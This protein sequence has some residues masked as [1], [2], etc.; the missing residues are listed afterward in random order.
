[1]LTGPPATV[2]WVSNGPGKDDAGGETREDGKTEISISP[3][4]VAEVKQRV[5]AV[6][7][8]KHIH[9]AGQAHTCSTAI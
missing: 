5:Q 3:A 7:M 9:M 4:N 2:P 1:M 8:R 6:S